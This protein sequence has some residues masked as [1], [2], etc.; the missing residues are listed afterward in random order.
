ML[1]HRYHPRV[2]IIIILIIIIKAGLLEHPFKL[3][4]VL[5]RLHGQEMLFMSDLLVTSLDQH[6][7]SLPSL[8][9]IV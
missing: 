5:H 8:E 7:F 4:P 9:M 6:V 2:I 3:L 1:C